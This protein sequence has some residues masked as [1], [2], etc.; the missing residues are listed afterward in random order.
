MSSNGQSHHHI[1]P[2]SVYINVG[3]A[4]LVLTVL[5][6]VVAQME[7]GVFNTILAMVIAITKASLVALF[8]M[9]LKYDN[10]LYLIV[11]L[12][13]IAF[14]GL[15]IILSMA[16]TETRGDIYEFRG[17]PINEDAVIYNR[18]GVAGIDTLAGEVA[19]T[20]TAATDTSAANQSESDTAGGQ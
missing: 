6:V 13:A 18:P 12:A 16:D 4:L 15:F 19:D 3:L 1:L 11:F 9:H 20:V 7:L 17:R 8:F 2:L 10:K 14:L 5:T